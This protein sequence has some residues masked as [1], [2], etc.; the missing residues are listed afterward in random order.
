MKQRIRIASLKCLADLVSAV[1]ADKLQPFKSKVILALA[2]VL[3]DPKRSVRKQ[4]VAARHK[5]L[6]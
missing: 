4:A 5:Y 3:D 2:A 6:Q 1:R